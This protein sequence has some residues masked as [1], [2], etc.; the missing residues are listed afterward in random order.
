MH[1]DSRFAEFF[2]KDMCYLKYPEVMEFYT[3]IDRQREDALKV[4]I[5]DIDTLCE[6]VKEKSG[7]P[8]GLNP[9]RFFQWKSSDK[10]IEKMQAELVDGV[11]ESNL[12]ASVKDHYADKDY[13]RCRP[14]HQELRD[15]LY[16]HSF[17]LMFNAIIGGSRSLRNSDYVAPEVKKE[18]LQKIMNCWDEVSKV[19]IILSPIL[20]KAKSAMFDGTWVVLEDGFE[21]DPEERFFSILNSIPSNVASWFQY[22]LFSQKMGPLLMSF[23][24]EENSDIVNHEMILL[25]INQRPRGWKNKVEAYIKTV[26]KNS[27]YL[28]DVHR[29]LRTQYRFSFAS[30]ET[31]KEIEYLIK[32]A[33]AKHLT[34]SKSP[35]NKLINKMEN[36]VPKREY[37]D[38]CLK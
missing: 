12:P 37:V 10:S 29:T 25:L 15:I 31:L 11:M 20:A 17:P 30:P 8:H 19:I 9:Y 28:W 6:A 1:H 5:R 38:D 16:D 21:D 4:I 23:S 18:L 13:D 35:S 3:G 2:F 34:G 32:M 26:S 7:L 14:Y 27:F 24:N 22:D 36:S 33:A